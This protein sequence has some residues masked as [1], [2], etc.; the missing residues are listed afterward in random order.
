M[1]GA[2][3]SFAWDLHI[4]NATAKY[5]LTHLCYRASIK[6]DEP[7]VHKC[8]PSIASIAQATSLCTKTVQRAINYLVKMN[9]ITKETRTL[10]NRKITSIYKIIGVEEHVQKKREDKLKAVEGLGLCVPTGRDTESY[11]PKNNKIKKYPKVPRKRIAYPDAFN[12]VCAAYPKFAEQRMSKSNAYLHWNSFCQA[13]KDCT[14][15]AVKNYA[16]TLTFDQ[17]KSPR[18]L[19]NFLKDGHWKRYFKKQ[20][21][22]KRQRNVIH[23]VQEG[24]QKKALTTD[25]A[26][27]IARQSGSQIVARSV[28]NNWHSQLIDFIMNAH[29]MPGPDEI[30]DILHNAAY[31]NKALDSETELTSPVIRKHNASVRKSREKLAKAL[32]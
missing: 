20:S 29:R 7:E 8:W 13:D 14:L 25:Q 26:I 9:I 31:I 2:A 19:E 15:Q 12:E 5:V 28:R 10:N 27:E 16:R 22:A 30:E 21:P 4:N 23:R 3:V 18:H 24:A 17:W 1:S 6:S 11:K 32:M